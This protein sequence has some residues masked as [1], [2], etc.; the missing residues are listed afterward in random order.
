L[1][2]F[3]K[4]YHIFWDV[5]DSN[6]IWMYIEMAKEWDNILFLNF[7]EDGKITSDFSK[8]FN[9]NSWLFGFRNTEVY[10]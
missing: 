3:Q 4:K 7:N 6:V 5:V 10:I 2:F 9:K 8:E 1:T